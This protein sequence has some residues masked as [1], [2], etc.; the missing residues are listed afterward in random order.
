MRPSP[1]FAKRI[2]FWS[3]VYGLI[4]LVPLCFLE[5]RLGRTFPPPRTHPE[6]FYGFIG[7]A[8]AWQLAFL[9]ISREPERLRPVM[10]AAIAEKLLPVAPLFALFSA[11]RVPIAAVVFATIDLALGGLFVISFLRCPSEAAKSHFLHAGACP[12]SSLTEDRTD[13]IDHG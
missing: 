9:I 3:G 12:P 10:I 8:L 2:F 1:V 6:N 5:D 7:V 4:V 11:S 13:G